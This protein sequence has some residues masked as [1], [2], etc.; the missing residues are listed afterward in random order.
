MPPTHSTLYLAPPIHTRTRNTLYLSHSHT[1]VLNLSHSRTPSFSFP[2]SHSTHSLYHIVSL[3]LSLFITYLTL[4]FSLSLFRS[5]SL[6]SCRVV[7]DGMEGTALVLQLLTPDP[8]ERLGTPPFYTPTPI[9]HPTLYPTPVPTPCPLQF[10]IPRINPPFSI[11]QSINH[12]NQSTHPK[13]N[14]THPTHPRCRH[15]KGLH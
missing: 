12:F 14:P 4:S 1:L 9:H 10:Q 2:P 3:F 7:S 15:S 8:S 5:L 11:K 13:P 6:S